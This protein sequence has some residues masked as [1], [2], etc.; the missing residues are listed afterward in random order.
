VR[1]DAEVD[2]FCTSCGMGI[3]VS[4]SVAKISNQSDK[5]LYFCCRR[6]LS[7]YENEL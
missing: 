7:F 2:T 1:T 6:C 4:L 5:I 3:N